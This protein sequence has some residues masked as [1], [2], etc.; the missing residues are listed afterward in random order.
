MTIN[1]SLFFFFLFGFINCTRGHDTLEDI[2]VYRATK[3][4]D[5]IIILFFFFFGLAARIFYLK[6]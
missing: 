5:D 3:D 4:F 6:K 2:Q 1:H